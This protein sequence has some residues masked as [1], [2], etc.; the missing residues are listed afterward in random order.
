MFINKVQFVVNTLRGIVF[1]MGKYTNVRLKS[2]IMLSINK[3]VNLY[4]KLIF[5][6]STL[7]MDL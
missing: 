3:T 4:S 5:K 2:I 6:V 7:P 1:I